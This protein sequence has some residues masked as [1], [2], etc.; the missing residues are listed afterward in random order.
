MSFYRKIEHL[1]SAMERAKQEGI[2]VNLLVGAGCSVSAGIPL[3]DGIVSD[4]EEKYAD[5]LE[6]MKK[7]NYGECMSKLTPVERRR[8]INNYVCKSKINWA[9][10]GIANLMK[11]GY[12]DRVLTTN[13]DNIIV[14]ACSLVGEYPGIYD[15]AMCQDFRSD[16]ISEKSVLYLHGQHTGFV[17]CNTKS[18]IKAQKEKLTPILKNFKEKSMWIIIG[19]SCQND[20]VWEILKEEKS[21]ENRLYLIGYKESL[22]NDNMKKILGESKYSFYI[23]GYD[24][25]SFFITLMKRLD[26]FPPKIIEKPFSYLE[27]TLNDITPYRENESYFKEDI[28][29][30][31]KNILNDAIREFEEDKV[32]MAKFYYQINMHDKFVEMIREIDESKNRAELVKRLSKAIEDE[33]SKYFKRVE[34]FLDDDY[35]LDDANILERLEEATIIT[36]IDVDS[37]RCYELQ[38]KIDFIYDSVDKSK[39]TSSNIISRCNLLLDLYIH[40]KT[41]AVFLEKAVN[42]FEENVHLFKQKHEYEINLCQIYINLI[43]WN[44]INNNLEEKNNFIAMAFELLDSIESKVNSDEHTLLNLGTLYL[45]IVNYVDDKESIFDKSTECFEIA[46]DISNNPKVITQWTSRLKEISFDVEVELDKRR[47]LIPFGKLK[48]IIEMENNNIDIS[49]FVWSEVVMDIIGSK[50]ISDY[51][52]Y[53]E[54]YLNVVTSNI[55]KFKSVN[56]D[57]LFNSIAYK[58]IVIGEYDVALSIIQSGL[59]INRANPYLIATLGFWYYNNEKIDIE[60]AL[61][62]GALNY[63]KAISIVED[64]YEKENFKQKYRFESSKF[65][66][67]RS[68]DADLGKKNILDIYNNYE[69]SLIKSLYFEIEAYVMDNILNNNDTRFDEINSKPVVEFVATGEV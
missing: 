2:Q 23:K 56:C 58:L 48:N 64:T 44:A 62:N 8:L 7:K 65:Q 46:Y 50:S 1:V 20:A 35:C 36:G 37:E 25:D 57:E 39:F 14:K 33:D 6:G 40:D 22:P 54:I 53:V 49:L 5:E 63:E 52:K 11:Q 21:F 34:Q 29:T 27:E 12:I 47:L 16:L 43:E 59:R 60:Q 17:L 24:A 18:E 30:I 32:K 31:T 41:T 66:I 19:Y 9:H 68:L 42:I 3:A 55:E 28:H 4:L 61:E 38:K 45:R 26:Q 67:N 13:F 15:L 69:S 51:K 10:I